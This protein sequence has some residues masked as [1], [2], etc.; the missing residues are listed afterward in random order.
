MAKE[1]RLKPLGLKLL[2]EREYGQS[3]IW[4]FTHEEED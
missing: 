3:R 4:V 2:W 1:R